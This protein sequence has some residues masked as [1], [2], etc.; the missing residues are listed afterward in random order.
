M[1]VALRTT[2]ILVL[3]ALINDGRKSF[4]QISREAGISTP[5]VKARFNRLV[6]MGV[7]K[8]ISP[9]VDPDKVEYNYEYRND[10]NKQKHANPRQQKQLIKLVKTMK[11][12]NAGILDIASRLKRGMIVKLKCDY[13]KNPILA[14]LHIFKFANYERFF[15]CNECRMAYKRKYGGRIRSIRKKGL[16]V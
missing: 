11:I 6:N 3:K 14:K 12:S 9:I 15:C 5:T 7:I 8:S 10:E 2:D 1:V 4:R 16:T 13:C